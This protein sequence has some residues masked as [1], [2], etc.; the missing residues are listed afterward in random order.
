[1]TRLYVYM[2][3]L[4]G[5]L[6]LFPQ[7]TYA[8]YCTA[9]GP[10]STADSNIEGVNLTGD[11]TNIAYT[12]CPGV[13]GVEDLTATQ[14]ADVTAG[15]G[16]T[17]N[18]G[19]GT[20][21]GNYGGAG[22][23]WIDWNQNDIFDAGESIG[24]WAG[25]PPVAVSAFAFVV[26][27]TAYNGTTRMRVIQQES[28][29]NPL[30]PCASFNWGSVIDVSIVVSG[31]VT[32]TCADPNALTATNITSTGADLGWVDNASAG[33][34]NVEYGTTGFALGTGTQIM[35]TTNNPESVTGLTPST[36]YQFYIQTDCGG[37]D[38]SVW[39]GPFDFLTLCAPFIAPWTDN[40][41]AITPVQG[42]SS[43]NCWAANA[44]TTYDWNITGTGTTPSSAT[45]ALTA[46]SGAN[47][48]YTEAS[49]LEVGAIANLLTPT[50]DATALTVPEL[51]FW[52]HMTGAQMGSVAIEAWNGATWNQVDIITGSQQ[53]AQA[54]A[55]LERNV[56]LVGYNIIDLQ[57]RFVATS[58]GGGW[59]GDIC[60]DDISVNEAPT[61]PAPIALA[62]DSSDLT[63]GSFSWTPT[64][65]ET[66]WEIE[67]GPAGFSPGTGTIVFT[68]PNPW[69]TITGL[70]SNSF[71]DVYVMGVCGVA[72]SSLQ[73][74]PIG[75]DTY[76]QGQFMDWN[77]ECG[78]GFIDISSTG[79]ATNMTDDASIDVVL[80]FSLLFQGTIVNNVSIADNG[81]LMMGV[82][83]APYYSWSNNTVANAPF[84][85][86]IA[87]WDDIAIYAANGGEVYYE[88]QGTAPNQT[89]IVQWNAQNVFFGANGDDITY[90]IQIDE[91]TGEIYVVYE[92]TEFA[93]GIFNNDGAS[94]TIG[95]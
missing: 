2:F 91:A 30:D 44:T 62:I 61:C 3:A 69:Y 1:M 18:V 46:N 38:L 95:L 65:S 33:L 78:P 24:I 17:A 23:A 8:Q 68:S 67:Y 19:F 7:H 58:I 45:G 71:Y 10:M 32:I 16:Y 48:F 60:I 29:A 74:G 90:Q 22:E 92:D 85:S 89:F 4:I 86:V 64:G 72:D 81:A 31:G 51:K 37:G 25:I 35:G 57:I 93:A 70:T 73:V 79:T 94:A 12:G 83:G 42:F 75:F 77:S 49:G 6:L 34:S 26:P 50:I 9:G 27:L 15:S 41:D 82:T 20:C 63:T 56:L 66:E 13:L 52:Y 80:P 54:D 55:F 59:E 5:A 84:E 11:A 47:Y 76:N 28:G 39:V 87:F 53:G 40:V 21:G 14:S 36:G 43:G 88:T